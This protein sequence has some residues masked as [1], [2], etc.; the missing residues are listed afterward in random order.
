MKTE[1]K[2]LKESKVIAITYDVE[3]LKNWEFSSDLKQKNEYY[4]YLFDAEALNKFDGSSNFGDYGKES[5]EKIYAG[6]SEFE[7]TYNPMSRINNPTKSIRRKKKYNDCDGELSIDRYLNGSDFYWM[8]K[9]KTEVK[10]MSNRLSIY[11]SSSAN[12]GNSPE[13][14]KDFV[15][16]VV[17]KI[18]DKTNAGYSVEVYHTKYNAGVLSK[19][20]N[21]KQIADVITRTKLKEAGQYLDFKRLACA[22]YPAMHRF[23]AYKSFLLAGRQLDYGLGYPRSGTSVSVKVNEVWNETAVKTEVY[24][25]QTWLEN[26]RNLKEE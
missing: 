11:I 23:V 18:Q 15:Y 6:N 20:K 4:S 21:S 13:E 14:I 8:Q 22:C 16:D 17:N 1:I 3:E 12:A 24:D 10:G 25:F 2:T 26:G 5:V 9:T 19:P 7:P